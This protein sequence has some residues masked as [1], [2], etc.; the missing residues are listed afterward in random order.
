M[1]NYKNKLLYDNN[2]F[3]LY[4]GDCLEIMKLL[5]DASINMIFADPPYMLSNDG[6][7]C[8]NGRM[9]SVNKG[10]WDKSKGF[11]E[12]LIFHE[13]WI[14]ECRRVLAENGTIWISGTYHSIYQCG[15]LLQ[16]LGFHILNDISW[17][18]P[19]AS[20]NLSCRFFTASHENLIWAK[21]D[22][23]AKHTFNYDLMKNG[24]F[25][26]D[27]MKKPNTQM[28]SVWSIPTTKKSE[29]L[30][31]KHPTQKPLDLLKRIII[32]STNNGDIILDPFNGSGT[33][34]IATHLVGKSRKYIGID[35]D[36]EY[37]N[38]TINRLKSILGE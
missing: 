24:T 36:K 32:A 8:L 25:N 11:E 37:L 18:K 33:T 26:E 34:G 7:S 16:K 31:G 38:L 22:K 13:S 10:K 4:Y 17:F 2:N 9:V 27:P 15:F 3:S 12:D 19:N 28:R 30:Q 23:K 6:F 29:K 35:M 1:N 21:K 5:P 14:S 20:P